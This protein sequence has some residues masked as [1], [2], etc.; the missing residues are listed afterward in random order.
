MSFP[1]LKISAY[2]IDGNGL[3]DRDFALDPLAGDPLDPEGAEAPAADVSIFGVRV[4]LG[5]V[6]LEEECRDGSGVP[7]DDGGPIDIVFNIDG[8]VDVLGLDAGYTLSSTPTVC[9]TS[10]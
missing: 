4:K 2:D 1:S 8:S 6:T 7:I 5:G 3:Q 9:M 10:R